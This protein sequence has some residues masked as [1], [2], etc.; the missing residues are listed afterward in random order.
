M[1]DG[2]V[3]LFIGVPLSPETRADLAETAEELMR[4]SE[5]AGVVLRWVPPTNYHI[6]IKFLGWARRE[7]VAAIRDRV[8]AAIAGTGRAELSVLGVSAFP[9]LSRARVLW[10]GIGEGGE[11]LA[12]LARAV[13]EAVTPLGFASEQRDFHAHVTLARCKGKDLSGLVEGLSERVFSKTSL[14][15]LVLYESSLKPT[16]S[17]YQELWRW[18]LE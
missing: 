7:V 4:R 11:R 5:E 3:R 17:E 8:A 13:E 9:T 14:R 1:R 18:S 15:S 12:A 6:T 16:G 2:P 10:A